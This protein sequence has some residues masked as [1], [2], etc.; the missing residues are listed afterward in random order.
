MA[1][2]P[3]LIETRQQAVGLA[4]EAAHGELDV[5]TCTGM[6]VSLPMRRSSSIAGQKLRSSLR[7]CEM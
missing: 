7:T 1:R 2:A 4:P 5:Q 6:P 3:R